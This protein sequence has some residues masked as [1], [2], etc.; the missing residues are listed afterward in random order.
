M[1]LFA[2]NPEENLLARDGQVFYHGPIMTPTQAD[3]IFAQLFTEIPWEN[4]T[5]RLF[6]KTITTARKMAW[7]GERDFGYTYSGYTRHARPWTPALRK[8]KSLIES[9]SLQKFNS[10]LLNLYHNGSEGMT[11]H[12]DDEKSL[13]G[14]SAIASLSL[15]AERPFSLKHRKFALREKIILEHGSLLVMAGETQTHWLHSIPKSKK[16]V[17]PRIS[18]TFRR[19]KDDD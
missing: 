13:V 5:V 19:M 17:A 8:I 11:W 1:D 2:A 9:R 10:C 7:F 4:D 16:I 14:S 6:G 15:G 18:L 12:S 3:A